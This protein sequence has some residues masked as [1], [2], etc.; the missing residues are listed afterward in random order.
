MKLVVRSVTRRTGP[1]GVYRQPLTIV[2]R[3]VVLDPW[4]RITPAAAGEVLVEGNQILISP[5]FPGAGEVLIESIAPTIS[6]TTPLVVAGR[7][8]R[9]IVSRRVV[10]STVSS[11]VY[12][13]ATTSVRRVSLIIVSSGLTIRPAAGEVLI[14]GGQV[15]I[16]PRT[17][18]AGEVLIDG[19]AVTLTRGGAWIISPGAG[20]V[21]IV[22][23]PPAVYSP[24]VILA[25]INN[26]VRRRRFA[27]R[28]SSSYPPPPYDV[29]TRALLQPPYGRLVQI[30]AGEVLIVG[31]APALRVDSFYFSGAGTGEV[32]IE[33][34]APFTFWSRDVPAGASEVLISGYPVLITNVSTSVSAGSSVVEIVGY[35][36]GI[37]IVIGWSEMG[38]GSAT[39]SAS[40]AVVGSWSDVVVTTSI[41]TRQ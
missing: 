36:P 5:R 25:A 31:D 10:R 23:S 19:N 37:E 40:T 15:G 35:N 8:E 16:M 11:G 29:L 20:E 26:A 41:W 24:G 33:S 21:L 17:P 13:Q 2:R 6:S 27:A 9:T 12:R 22:G 39:W 7:V 30:G 3:F 4:T 14:E 38:V 28:Y 1:S 34:G 32:V 18:G